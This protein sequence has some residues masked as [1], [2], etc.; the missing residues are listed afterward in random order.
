MRSNVYSPIFVYFSQSFFAAKFIMPRLATLEAEMLLTLW[1]LSLLLV[2]PPFNNLF[3]AY[4]RA[5]PLILAVAYL[6]VSHKS[7]KLLVAVFCDNCLK[8]FFD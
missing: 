1:T 6:V 2:F 8:L 4:L 7:Q 3:T 5:E